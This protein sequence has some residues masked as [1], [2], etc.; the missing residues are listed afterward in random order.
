ME[1]AL[2]SVFFYIK[3]II[4]VNIE[5]QKS[6]I[7]TERTLIKNKQKISIKLNDWL[8]SRLVSTYC[9]KSL[10]YFDK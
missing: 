1:K 8:D 3:H 9:D 10:D 6:S 4:I 7:I 5:E 2:Y